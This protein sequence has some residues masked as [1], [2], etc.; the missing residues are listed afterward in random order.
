MTAATHIIIA[1]GIILAVWWA[2][3]RLERATCKAIDDAFTEA[4]GDV[5]NA[6]KKL[7]RRSF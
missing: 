5:P 6:P 2:I 4:Y 7:K 1:L 3:R